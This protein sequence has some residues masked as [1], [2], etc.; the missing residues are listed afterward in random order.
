V[1]QIPRSVF[2]RLLGVCLVGFATVWLALVA[3]IVMTTARVGDAD[4]ERDLRLQASALARFS[5]GADSTA[6]IR[7]VAEHVRELN[8]QAAVPLMR[9]DE[10]TFQVWDGAGQLLVRS[11]EQPRLR[12][13]APGAVAIGRS[14]VEQGWIVFAEPSPDGRLLA[15]VGQ[16]DTIYARARDLV[17]R[18][19]V[20]PFAIL[21]LLLTALIWTGLRFGLRPL[22]ALAS[23][24][25]ARA[26]SDFSPVVTRGSYA[27]LEPLVTALN[28]K[29]LRIRALIDAERAF[30]ADAAHQLRTPIAAISAQAHVVSAEASPA[31]RAAAVEQL[32]LGVARAATIIH[33]LLTLARLD[34]VAPTGARARVSLAEIAAAV[35]G[36]LAPR[37]EVRGQ[38]LELVANDGG[39]VLGLRNELFV[40]VESLVENAIQHASPR[41]NICVSVTTLNENSEVIVEDDGPG[42]PAAE[43]A[44]VFERFARASTA[45]DSGSGLGLAIVKRIA[46]MHGGA[47]VLAETESRRGCRFVL[48]VP[49]ATSVNAAA[50]ST[51]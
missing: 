16:R 7:A 44:Q 38:R 6:A 40:A 42:I 33:R 19:L 14:Y 1:A 24:L 32:E 39:W 49:R 37:A 43:R 9:A 23:Q 4:V 27:E 31:R 15:I 26:A 30:F 11:E 13:L 47:I 45:S 8:V 3:Y 25:N 5:S 2:L 41:S 21:A 18:Q 48:S 10:F 17:R 20:L 28:E 12:D 51:R 35:V 36:A 29:L 50:L 22:R 46:D 34:A